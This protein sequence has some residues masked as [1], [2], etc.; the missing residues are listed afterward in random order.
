MI[1]IIF[2]R[3]HFRHVP[4]QPRLQSRASFRRILSLY[5]RNLAP[6]KNEV[7][8]KSDKNKHRCEILVLGYSQF[9]HFFILISKIIT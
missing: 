2:P 3:L 6:K 5:V 1:V 8:S 7:T 9:L 4:L